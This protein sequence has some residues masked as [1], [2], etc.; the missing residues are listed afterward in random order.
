MEPYIKSRYVSH[1]AMRRLRRL[2]GAKQ[3]PQPP[4]IFE[5]NN[6]K[7]DLNI[8][9]VQPNCGGTYTG[10]VGNNGCC[11]QQTLDTKQR[12]RTNGKYTH[13]HTHTQTRTNTQTRV[14]DPPCDAVVKRA[15]QCI[16]CTNSHAPFVNPFTDHKTYDSFTFCTHKLRNT[17]EKQI[18][19]QRNETS[20]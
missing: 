12:N 1:T 5:F 14:R 2:R 3:W 8:S 18:K 6:A 4:C 13:T 19:K 9:A 20:P 11:N 7:N 16:V 15:N 10:S 17:R